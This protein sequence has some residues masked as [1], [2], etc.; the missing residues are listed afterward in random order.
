[1]FDKKVHLNLLI[2]ET[3]LQ[4]ILFKTLLEEGISL[5]D[6]KPLHK[7]LGYESGYIFSINLIKLNK[8][9]KVL[10]SYTLHGKKR[11]EG[12]LRSLNGREIGR[13]VFFIPIE[14]AERFKEFLELWNVDF[15]M[16]KILKG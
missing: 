14:Y 4:N 5:I 3:L 15:Y 11:R 12:I 6:Q 8:S 10:F 16:M 9:K 7:K 1:H 2:I 13:A